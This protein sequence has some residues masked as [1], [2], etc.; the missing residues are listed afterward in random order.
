MS[1][2]EDGEFI[3]TPPP[4]KKPDMV[5][6]S[7]PTKTLFKGTTEFTT[8]RRVSHRDATGMLGHVIKL[9]GASLEPFSLSKS[10]SYRHRLEEVK[11]IASKIKKDFK[12]DMPKHIVLHWDSKLIK[13]KDKHFEERLAVVISCPDTAKDQRFIAA[14]IMPNSKGQSQKNALVQVLEDWEIPKKFLIGF[15]WDTTAS[16]TGIHRGSVFLVERWLGHSVLDLACRHHI[17]ELHITHGD[18]EIRGSRIGKYL[19]SLDN[20][21][22]LLLCHH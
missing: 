7:L 18:T 22:M 8:R 21:H 5:T 4:S 1:D 6:I 12:A 13:F 14:P 16:N 11:S 20:A 3:Y 17:G 10:T 15:S 9:G 2:S 19:F